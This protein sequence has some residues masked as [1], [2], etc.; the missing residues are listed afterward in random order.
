MM[1][2]MI[3]A[4]PT[5][6]FGQPEINLGVSPGGGGTQRLTQIVGKYRAMELMLTGRNFSAEEAE[7]WGLVNRIVGPGE[8]EVVKEA[9]E[10]ARKISSKSQIASQATKEMINAAYELPL[11]EGVRFERRLFFGLFNTN[12]KNEGKCNHLGFH[13][14]IS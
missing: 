14:D 6:T 11:T 10:L 9:V 5:A 2:D 7:K 12:D 8:G 1:C 13:E 4:S 3:L